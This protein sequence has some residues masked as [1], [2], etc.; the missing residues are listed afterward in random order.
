MAQAEVLKAQK[1]YDKALKS[2]REDIELWYT[3]IAKNNNISLAE[4]KRML[5]KK[6]R[7]E[8][9]WTIDNYIKH[10]QENGIS[11]DWSR[12]LENA[13]AKYHIER[14]EVMQLQIR[15]EIEKLYNKREN[16]MGEYLKDV[17]KDQYYRT[18]F[19]IAK[20]T[21]VGTNLYKLND[22]LVNNIIHK[23]W[24]PDGK[25]FSERIWADKDKLINTLH[26]EITQGFIRGDAA[27][28]II[29]RVS[30]KMNV[31]KANAARLVYTESAAYS[32]KARLKSYQ[33]LGLEK[34]E[35]VATLDSRTSEI[36]QEMDGKV[37]DLKD[38]EVG[39][40]APPYHVRCRSTTAP[41]FDDDKGERAARN[42]TT[43]KTEYAPANMKYKD[44]KEKHI[45]E[46]NA[47]TGYNIKE[48]LNT[49]QTK[50][51]DNILD[52]APEEFKKAWDVYKDDFKIIDFVEN[53]KDSY[54]H[55]ND[56][57]QGMYIT[58]K[59]LMGNKTWLKP[60]EMFFHEAGHQ[61]DHL[62]NLKKLK[63]FEGYYISDI[64]RSIKYKNF[65][66]GSMLEAEY[67]DYINLIK[68]G[69]NLSNSEVFKIIKDKYKNRSA[70]SIKELSDL[71]SGLSKGG[72][73]LG[74]GHRKE[75]WE[76]IP[77]SKEAFAE[78][79]SSLATNPESLKLLK[80]VFPKSYE[81]YLEMLEYGALE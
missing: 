76:N 39:V 64:W 65:T 27:D 62:I 77:V 31:S 61:L 26:T 34:Y 40:T 72:F 9:R 15:G 25:G 6:E 17:F 50:V 70:N 35:V 30:E 29:N 1:E 32:S 51:L 4:A 5:T 55:Y 38:Y 49:E 57:L 73:S 45:V 75:Y 68:D 67:S 44:W 52:K 81:I 48:K 3:R 47:K 13:S 10:G 24:A 58:K 12:E 66:L 18:A 60:F 19:E 78:F 54:P 42:E 56:E 7:E 41:Y 36:C 79:T 21:G 71:F 80:E 16:R 14:L 74:F 20:G 11:A 46:E 28:K 43:G 69:K 53:L 63:G 8:F 23:P 22:G 2:I 33:D 37:F 59:D